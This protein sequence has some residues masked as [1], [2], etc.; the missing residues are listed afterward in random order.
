MIAL[1]GLPRVRRPDLDPVLMDRATDGAARLTCAACGSAPILMLSTAYAGFVPLRTLLI[2]VVVPAYGAIIA[3]GWLLPN[4]GRRAVTGFLAGIVAVLVYDLTRLALSYSQGGGD[5]IPHIGTMIFGDGTGWWV[6]YAWRTLGNGAGMGVIFTMLCPKKWWGPKL[7][8]VYASMIGLGMLGFLSLFPVA[9]TKLFPVNWQT[10]VNSSLGH[11][12]YGLMLGTMARGALR[13]QARRPK[14]R[15]AA[16]DEVRVA[17][18]G[19]P[20]S[21]PA[22]PR[23][24]G[25]PAGG[26]DWAADPAPRTTGTGWA[27]P[28]GDPTELL[29]KVPD[30]PTHAPRRRRRGAHSRS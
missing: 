26:E 4:V 2:F 11:A 5:P 27:R 8:L 30:V 10:M 24:S 13:R 29:P 17:G 28:P 16:P 22:V 21:R 7:G 23:W 15:H 14:G 25:T 3:L 19:E 20:A 6:G 12:T 18:P 9:Q 1:V